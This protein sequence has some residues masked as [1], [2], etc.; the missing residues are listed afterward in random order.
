MSTE[1]SIKQ[2]TVCFCKYHP[3]P[4]QAANAKPLLEKLLGVLQ[5]ERIAPRC[6]RVQYRIEQT[7]LQQIE[8][9][10][11]AAA[12]NLDVSLTAQLRR[13]LVYYTEQNER[14]NLAHPLERDLELRQVFVNRYEHKPHGCRD[15]RRKHFRDYL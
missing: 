3:D 7:G 14:D 11:K 6:L 1:S 13:S 15:P 10:L 5:V 2:R 8:E 4:E 12:F 9:A